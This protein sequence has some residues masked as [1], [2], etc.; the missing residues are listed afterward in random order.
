MSVGVTTARERGGAAAGPPSCWLEGGLALLD[1]GRRV[2]RVNLSLGRWL[3]SLGC[4]PVGQRFE[5]V[6]A[7]LG[8]EWETAFAPAWQGEGEPFFQ[9]QL[10]ANPAGHPAWY[11]VEATRPG[12]G[13]VVRVQS[14]LPPLA[15]L[16]ETPWNAHLAGEWEQRRMFMRLLRAEAQLS[17]LMRSLPGV[18][19]SQRA[20]FA[21]QFVSSQVSALTGVSAEEWVGQSRSFWEV[22]HEADAEELQQQC[23]RAVRGR[24][25]VATNFRLR[26]LKT[27]QIAHVLEHR[28]A[29]VSAGGLVIG[30]EGFWLDVTRQK[31]AERRLSSAA[32][33]ETLATLT[34][35]LAHDFSNI[36]AGILSLA[37]TFRAQVDGEHPFAEGLGLIRQN[38]WQACQLVQRMMHLHRCTTGEMGYHDLNETVTE[39]AD[40][41]QRVLPRRIRIETELATQPLPLYV[42]G[43][44]LRQVI[45]NLAL[46]AAEAMPQRG[47]LRFE[48]RLCEA[49]ALPEHAQGTLPALPCV[50]LCARD[51]GCGIAA[52]H[53]PYIFDPFFTTKPVN[54]GS[55]LG[56]YNA[57]LFVER[58][59]GAIAVE[60]REGEG[61]AFR[62]WLPLADFTEAE[63][64]ASA[65]V[66]RRPSLLL[67]GEPGMLHDSTA[68]FLRVQGFYVRQA[69]A[70]DR[71]RDALLAEEHP[72]RG[73]LILAGPAEGALLGLV[74]EL[75]S[76]RPGVKRILQLVGGE[77]DLVPAEVRRQLDLVITNEMNEE[78]MVRSLKQLCE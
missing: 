35:G 8:P 29:V 40:L 46:N 43:V 2:E 13:W 70:P 74:D 65:A 22:V 7:T 28:E 30:Y 66:Q 78:A 62:L 25:G 41:V 68:E 39:L 32:W 56:L 3:R 72:F 20:D 73:V 42:D 34:M 44:E 11:E 75:G 69:F 58:H 9:A 17:H 63:R 53:L 55:G 60:T 57:R 10:R 51:S 64:V 16:A 15:E 50:C 33:K 18:I 19:F 4:D 1:E 45:L 6:L 12:S 49:A 31:L 5:A 26:N 52:R 23:R 61:A 21:F 77:P 36:L 38:A 54:K 48:T 59:R 27:G 14:M 71:A 24:E 67:V 76:L 47:R 37:D